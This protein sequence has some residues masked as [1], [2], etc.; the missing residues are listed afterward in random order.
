VVYDFSRK[1]G[2]NVRVMIVFFIFIM[3]EVT[4]VPELMEI[5]IKERVLQI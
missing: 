4:H 3:V 5:S 1:E 2:W